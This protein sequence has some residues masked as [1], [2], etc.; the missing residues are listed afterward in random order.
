METIKADNLLDSL[1]TAQENQSAEFSTEHGEIMDTSNNGPPNREVM[2]SRCKKEVL[3]E[4]QITEDIRSF[5]EETHLA[6]Y[7]QISATEIAMLNK[8]WPQESYTKS[9]V[10]IGNPLQEVSGDVL[11]AIKSKNDNPYILS[12]FE[13]RHAGLKDL[14]K[15]ELEDGQIQFLENTTKTKSGVRKCHGRVYVMSGESIQ[16]HY[17][18]LKELGN[19]MK[20]PICRKISIVAA[21]ET[22]RT[23]IRK[24]VEIVFFQTEVEIDVYVPKK[25]NRGQAQENKYDTI[26]VNSSVEGRTYSD[27]LR[28]V[29]ENIDPENLGINIKSMRKRKDDSILIVTEKNHV[30][31]L[32]KEITENC[33]MKDIHIVDKKCDLLITGMDAITTKEEILKAIEVSG[34]LT[35]DDINKLE[36]KNIYANRSGEQVATIS[37]VKEIADKV[38][39]TGHLR[40]GWSRCRIKEKVSIPRCSNC[41]RVG[42]VN[43]SCKTKA[44]GN[45]K[46]L[47]CTQAG[48]EAKDCTNTSHCNSC[49]KSGHRADSMSCPMYRKKVYEKERSMAQ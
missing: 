23:S 25:E 32:K 47:N 35:E 10:K 20:E 3:D 31:A 39:P 18:A 30:D 19:E 37:T 29:R 17:T 13:E 43:R 38:I 46:C 11:L 33:N 27:M 40:I 1:G 15:E 48:H 26:V 9:T 16:D 6:D 8:K 14:I 34:S 44:T 28:T 49:S 2:C 21:N 5:V 22:I 45:K 41:L 4:K 36:I 24:L 12:K 42:H 7:D